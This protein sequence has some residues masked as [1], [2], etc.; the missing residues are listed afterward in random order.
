MRFVFWESCF[1][2]V[3]SFGAFNQ[4]IGSWDVSK[5]YVMDYMFSEAKDFN[6]DISSWDVSK[7]EY[8]SNFYDDTPQW[9]LPKPN[10]N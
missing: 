8:Y 10:F 2:I 7:V 5:V 3:F 9:T 6:Q 4:D 1:L